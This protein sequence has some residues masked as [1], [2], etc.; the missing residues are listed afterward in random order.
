M[1]R[2]SQSQRGV[3]SMYRRGLRLIRTKP[4]VRVYLSPWLHVRL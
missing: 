3:M 2:Y 4:E 1:K